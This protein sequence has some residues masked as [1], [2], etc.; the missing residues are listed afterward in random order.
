MKR[1]H[2]HARRLAL[3]VVA[4]AG[5]ACAADPPRQSDGGPTGVGGSTGGAGGGGTGGG[6]PRTGGPPP[7]PPGPGDLPQP[8]GTPG[9][10]KVLDWAGFKAAITYTFDDAQPSQVEH[11]AELQAAGVRHTFYVTSSS[12]GFDATFTQ[13][14]K[15]GHEMGNHTVHHATP[16]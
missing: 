4:F 2:I 15:D 6:P 1:S 9:N 7:G 10:L 3:A 8:S 11:Y 14:V 12:G 13:A 5:I 16:T